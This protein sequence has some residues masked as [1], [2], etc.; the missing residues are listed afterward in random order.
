MWHALTAEE[1]AARLDVDPARGLTVEEART[2]L[3]TYG[4]NALAEAKAEPVWRQFLK[5]YTEYMQIVLVVAAVVS[6][7]IGE[8]GTAIGLTVLTLFNAWLAYHQEGQAEAAAAAL[9]A[10]MKTWRR[11]AAAGRSSRSRP[12]RSCPATSSSS[13]PATGCRQTAG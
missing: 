6:V 2:R 1:V 5:H 12:T 8:W 3:A 10:M 11:Y 7:L 4:P 13:T 9:G